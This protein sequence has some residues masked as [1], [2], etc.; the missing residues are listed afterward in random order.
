MLV[1]GLP[2]ATFGSTYPR[3]ALT[4]SVA[5]LATIATLSIQMF[6]CPHVAD[7][8]MMVLFV[9]APGGP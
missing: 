7:R 9:C 8:P 6:A 3:R 5:L 2:V 4:Y 1:D